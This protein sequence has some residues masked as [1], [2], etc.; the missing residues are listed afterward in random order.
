LFLNPRHND[1]LLSSSIS[2]LI[3]DSVF[4]RLTDFSICEIYLKIEGFNPAGSIK[5]KT[6]L[7]LIS[8]LERSG[9]IRKDTILI[10]SSSGNLGVAISAVA[11]ERGYRFVCVVDPNT[12]PNNIK[13]MKAFGS[14]II[15]A[16][17][18]ADHREPCWLEF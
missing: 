9:S 13:I 16:F 17:F 6:A 7:G 8:D 10:E 15:M 11:A 1:M 18:W 2:T 3:N 12:S 14:E 4:H 5:L